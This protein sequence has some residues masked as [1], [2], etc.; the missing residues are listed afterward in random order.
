MNA[1]RFG[2]FLR[3]V[4]LAASVGAVLWCVASAQDAPGGGR[5][6][7]DVPIASSQDL[8]V[9]G[10]VLRVD[11][12]AGALDLPKETLVAHIRT[13]AEAVTTY[14]GH[15]PVQHARVLVIPI[16]GRGGGDVG[17]TTWG[18]M[19]G[20]QGLTRLRIGEHMTADA[21]KDD[22]TTTHELVHMAFP[23]M[24]DD[25][26][27]MEEGIATY[28]EP[29][30]RVM[31]GEL[32]SR[33][34]WGD[35]FR[36][37]HQGEPASGDEGMDRTHTW[38]RTYWGGA[39]FCLSA[40]VE[41]RKETGNRKGLRD[42]LQAIVAAGGTIDH[43]WDLPKALA[44]GDSATGTHV[45]TNLYAAWKDKPVEVDLPKLWADLG[46][47]AGA[48][49][50]EFDDSAPLAKIREGIAARRVKQELRGGI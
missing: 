32:T 45:L 27:W 40:D 50:V 2:W 11:I 44:V 20:W 9:G 1:R 30:S 3:R 5:G 31:T 38:G 8:K 12:A 21:L 17:G 15:F 47:R 16:E 24:P 7:W 37:M 35:M 4:L 25:Q 29:L 6:R 28:V 10:A 19:R 43:D 46:V 41:I 48:D 36:D 13:A 39:L 22:W 23:S 34:V 26:H 42:A 18:D 14:Y 49:G 33:K